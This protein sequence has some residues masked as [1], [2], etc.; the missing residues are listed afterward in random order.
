MEP[1]SNL[2][3]P[4]KYP[5]LASNNPVHDSRDDVDE[6]STSRKHSWSYTLKASDCRRLVA[7]RGWKKC[8]SCP[9]CCLELAKLP[10]KETNEERIA[11]YKFEE[12]EIKRA[13]KK[14][15][16]KSRMGSRPPLVSFSPCLVNCWNFE[17]GFIIYHLRH[18]LSP[19]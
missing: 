6:K 17:L 1:T 9:T 8:Y 13:K 16:K 19:I 10:P 7:H 15:R 3:T 5:R 11:S 14:Q 4:P 18:D 12:R 2:K